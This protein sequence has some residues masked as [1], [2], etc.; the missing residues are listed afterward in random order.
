MTEE[1]M[2]V[3][4]STIKSE[5]FYDWYMSLSTEDIALYKKVFESLDKK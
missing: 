5:D 4:L 2:K 1:Q 3:I